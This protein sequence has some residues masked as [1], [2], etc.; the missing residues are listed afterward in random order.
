MLKEEAPYGRQ[1]D[2][3]IAK[4]T[5]VSVATALD[6]AATTSC[7]VIRVVVVIAVRIKVRVKVF[8]RGKNGTI[9]FYLFLCFR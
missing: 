1:K 4:K 6:A 2:L 3:A 9:L 5:A 7:R 8:V